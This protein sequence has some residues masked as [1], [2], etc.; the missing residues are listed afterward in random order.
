LASTQVDDGRTSEARGGLIGLALAG[1]SHVYPVPGAAITALI[2]AGVVLGVVGDA[3]LFDANDVALNLSLWIGLWAAAAVVL[4]RR[5]G[6]A[7]D[8]ERTGWLAIGVVFASGLAWRDGPPL[9]LLA[10][11]CTAAAF[12][13]ATHRKSAA[14]VRRAGVMH[15]A[16]ALALGA[17]HAWMAGGLALVDAT[18]SA[19]RAGAS[20]ASGWRRAASVGRGLLIAAPLLVVFG[21]LFASADA[22]FADLVRNVF[23]FDFDRLMGRVV[24][25]VILA[26]I[27]IGGLRGFLTGTAFPSPVDRDPAIGGRRAPGPAPLGLGITEVSTAMAAVDLLFLIFV[28]VQFRY[29][30]GAD[31]L[32][33]VTPNLTYADYARRGFFEL[34]AAVVLVVPVLLAAD[35]LVDQ[36][37]PREVRVFRSL[38]GVQVGLVLAVAA[39]A[40][41]RLRLYHA[42][43]GLTEARFYAMTLL[44]WIVAMLV[45]LAATVL[46]G[47]RGAFA[48]GALASG[49]ATVAA[50]FVAN[51]DA[52]VSRTNAAR[53]ASTNTSV[54]FD[55]AYASSLSADAV[56]ALVDA[57]PTLPADAQCPLARQL[58]RRWPPDAER[59]IRDWNWSVTH[60]SAVVRTH[61]AALRSI[62]GTDQK[63]A[64]P[65]AK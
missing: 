5:L 54:P 63:C 8:A 36:R 3:L 10:L 12:A 14:W 53:M 24:L 57:L 49:L 4:H 16:A 19:A 46:R 20:H 45:W 30:F 65:G 9:K 61:E 39:S 2:V 31:A 43:Y 37:V 58:L 21:A 56:P 62:A 7:L 22:V 55:V 28:V 33:Q 47:R 32:V 38:A 35:W 44:V 60:A 23:R 18:R 6:S 15:Y 11:A 40:A 1:I 25:F 48:F 42:S 59:S 17:L 51:P 26:W 34:V 52:V 64:A 50:L 13:F 41:E 29:L 27:S